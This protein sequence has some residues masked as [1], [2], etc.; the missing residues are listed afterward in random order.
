MT[1]YLAFLLLFFFSPAQAQVQAHAAAVPTITVSVAADASS[2]ERAHVL[3]AVNEWNVALQGKGR[4]E[5]VDGKAE[6]QVVFA[7]G[8][9]RPGWC[10]FGT[11]GMGF[12][13]LYMKCIER[14]GGGSVSGRIQATLVHELGHVLGLPHFEGGIMSAQCCNGSEIDPLT[15]KLAAV[16]LNA[17]QRK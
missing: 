6:W 15:A 14:M 7:N 9:A 16:Y 10:A 2:Y 1:R 12:V 5:I 8:N 17:R 3:R 13:T 4:F 11:T